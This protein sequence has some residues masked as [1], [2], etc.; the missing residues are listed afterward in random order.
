[1][2]FCWL[3]A[4]FLVVYDP[5][6]ILFTTIFTFGAEKSWL[7]GCIPLGVYTRILATAGFSVGVFGGKRVCARTMDC[8]SCLFPFKH[9]AF[10]N[11]SVWHWNTF[12]AKK[13]CLQLK[14]QICEY[15][16]SFYRLIRYKH[17]YQKLLLLA[18]SPWS[19]LLNIFTHLLNIRFDE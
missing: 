11:F 14:R 16:H 8:K 10:R 2:F 5:S 1:M 17:C 7:F 15:M 9:M 19:S 4:V 6:A 18:A 3:V 12:L 13:A